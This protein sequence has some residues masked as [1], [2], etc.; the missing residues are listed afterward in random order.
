MPPIAGTAPAAPGGHGGPG[1][2]PTLLAAGLLLLLLAAGVKVLGSKP[3]V[4]ATA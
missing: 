1:V 4:V 3:P 2:D